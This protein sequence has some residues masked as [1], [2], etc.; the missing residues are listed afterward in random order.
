M[1][2]LP[3]WLAA[4]LD[5]Q[6]AA[7][8]TP[9]P[10][11]AAS[12]SAMVDLSEVVLGGRYRLDSLIGK[13][14]S[15]IV[16]RAH[17]Q[18]LGQDVAVKVLRR[19]GKDPLVSLRQETRLAM[20][21]SHPHV[22]RVFHYE[23]SG[24]W[25]FVV[26]EL[27]IG[28]NLHQLVQRRTHPVLSTR[29]LASFG[30]SVLSALAHAH[31]QG[32]VHNDLKPANILLCRRT[33]IK[34]CDFGLAQLTASLA[35]PSDTTAGTP[36]FMSPERI[37]G[38]PG[39]ARS[40][41]YSF[42]ATFFAL[43]VGRPP[44]G[45]SKDALRLHLEQPF[46]SDSSLPAPLH[47]VL[48]QAM[49]KSP[50]DRFA[51][52]SQMADAWEAAARAALAGGAG[53]SPRQRH[54]GVDPDAVDTDPKLLV[55][56]QS[57]QFRSMFD[58]PRTPTP[59][60]PSS[61]RIPALSGSGP[62]SSIF[63]STRPPAEPRQRHPTPLP[64]PP[65]RFESSSSPDLRGVA[66]GTVQVAG[67]TVRVHGFRLERLLVTNHD[68]GLFLAAD[69]GRP[70]DGWR[71]STPPRGRETWPVTGVTLE[72][73][74]AYARWR[75]RRLPTSIEW[76]L[77]YGPTRF[78]W[79]DDWRPDAVV[80]LHNSRGDAEPVGGRMLGTNPAGVFDLL[81][82]V[83]EWTEP[84]PYVPVPEAGRA[85]V[86]GGSYRHPCDAGGPPKTSVEQGKAYDYLGFRCAEGGQ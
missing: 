47:G 15:S 12:G 7:A 57:T 48:A 38:E 51:T 4:L 81:G 71:G 31:A 53:E 82:N 11:P 40:D 44:F 21:L 32:V 64:E 9:E 24:T 70:P 67:R 25:E 75:G 20:R 10:R 60:P 27:V 78:P 74:R 3:R 77:A 52:A 76:E 63:R 54:D 73:A 49:Q 79:G 46:P 80:G 23:L 84:D 50:R 13:G 86:Y 62:P 18:V 14:A 28:E 55:A 66:E 17:D 41:L 39:E 68:F 19:D 22:L 34:V 61:A 6:S 5:P 16:Y 72:Q 85:W 1:P 69:G 8:E 83:W 36:A 43:G 26:M 33:G 2:S 59:G 42:A 37:R 29:E 65:T 30:A 56:A 45:D 58:R 35:G